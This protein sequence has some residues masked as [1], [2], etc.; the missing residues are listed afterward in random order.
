MTGQ[1]K[2]M[3]YQA[4]AELLWKASADTYEASMKVSAFL[5]GSRSM[6]SVGQITA[7]GLAPTR[8]ADKSRS[9]LAAHFDAAKGKIVFSA[10]TPEAPWLEGVQDRVSVF[11]QLGG[12]LAAKPAP[13]EAGLS[14]TLYTVGPREA[15]AWTFVVEA[16]ENLELL[17]APMQTVKL[18]R[19]ARREFDQKVEVWYAP[20]LGYLP[21][22][23]RITQASGDFIDQQLSEVSRL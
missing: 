14:I 18:I 10:N 17:G 21:V 5:V 2:G 15:E 19:K 23:N 6:T 16:T 20:S 1:S 9:E 11:I 7:T 3:R 12:I 22:R 4:A 13:A 8:F